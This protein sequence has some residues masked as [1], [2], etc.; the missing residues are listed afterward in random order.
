MYTEGLYMQDLWGLYM[1]GL[2]Y[3]IIP[4]HQGAV[5]LY[6]ITS[7]HTFSHLSS[8]MQSIKDHGSSNICV[9]IVGH[10]V[11]FE[12]RRAVSSEEGREVC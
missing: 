1:Q 12:E 7:R 4:L 10:K 11:D 9:A 5:L 8:W 6:D 2:L 3:R